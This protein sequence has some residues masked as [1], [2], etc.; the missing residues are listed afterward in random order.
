MIPSKLLLLAGP[1]SCFTEHQGNTAC[2]LVRA[3]YPV[4]EECFP[5]P[6]CEHKCEVVNE[7]VCHIKQRKKCGVVNE[8][9]CKIV[10]ETECSS[11]TEKD[12]T[13][14]N[15]RECSTGEW[16]IPFKPLL[17]IINIHL[18]LYLIIVL[19][20]L[21]WRLRCRSNQRINHKLSLVRLP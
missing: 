21:S 5:V 1:I 19:H 15:D 9:A 13:I 20:K 17:T 11:F 18:C 10:Y 16:S 12:C 2:K 4:S 14:V 3:P 7:H 6:E 8:K